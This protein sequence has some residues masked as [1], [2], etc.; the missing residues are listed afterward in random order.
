MWVLLGQP[1][2]SIAVPTWVAVSDIPNPIGTCAMYDKVTTLQEK[3]PSN[4]EKLFEAERVQAAVLPAESHLFK[5]VNERLLPYWRTLVGPPD[6]GEMTRVEHQ[7]AQDAYSVVNYLATTSKFNLAPS[8]DFNVQQL[9]TQEYAFFSNVEDDGNLKKVSYLWNFGDS[10]TS[11]GPNSNHTFSNQGVYLVSV[12][13]TDD[14]GV[15][16]T[17]WRYLTVE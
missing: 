4:I 13:V 11:S 9:S 14:D 5:M 7:M 15:T 17:A 1:S 10:L 12:T 2:F 8:V 3:F 6:V 16:T